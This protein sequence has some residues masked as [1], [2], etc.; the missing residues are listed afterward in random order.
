MFNIAICKFTIASTNDDD[1]SKQV[2]V[3]SSN[4]VRH[5]I[6]VVGVKANDD[7]VIQSTY[8]KWYPI[9]SADDEE[10][11]QKHIDNLITNEYLQRAMHDSQIYEYLA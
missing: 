6:F 2:N 9:I 10:H 4:G 8:R 7:N 1:G 3:P 5:W 11:F